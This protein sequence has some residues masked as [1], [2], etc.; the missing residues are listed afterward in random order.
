[1]KVVVSGVVCTN[2]PVIVPDVNGVVRFVGEEMPSVL[3]IFALA[4]VVE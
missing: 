1:V 4:G 3:V 2:V